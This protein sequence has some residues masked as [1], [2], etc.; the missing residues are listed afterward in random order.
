M[1]TIGIKKI[2]SRALEEDLGLGDVTTDSIFLKDQMT[3]AELRAKQSGVFAGQEIFQEVMHQVDSKIELIWHKND[4]E[5]F[6]KG[7]VIVTLKGSVVSLLKAERVAL[8]FIQRMSGIATMTA[9]F[10]SRAEPYG[11]SIVDTRKTL[12][13]LRLL[14][15]MAVK[16]GGGKNHRMGLYD[17]VMI[18]DN[19]IEAA[20]SISEAVKRVKSQIGHTLKIE[21]EIKG[22]D[23]L[24]EAISSDV[25]II[26][27][28]NM[29]CEMMKEAVGLA[30]KKVILEASGNMTLDRIEEVAATGVDVISVGALT[31]SVEAVDMS[32][33]FE[34][35]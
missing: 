2:I 25:D 8:N 20:G 27:L 31:H 13:G 19:H 14:D 16:M 23:Q 15:K 18:K 24:K 1:K 29:D 35:L 28:D 17:A 5:A 32:L 22:L 33:I 7:D 10:V 4:G 26:M 21:V 6:V 34:N 9:A 12:P 3:G 11:V 30:N